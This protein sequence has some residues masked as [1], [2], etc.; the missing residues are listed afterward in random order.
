VG[1]KAPHEM[2]PTTRVARAW[3]TYRALVVPANAIDIQVRECRRAFYA[4]A[5]A[6]LNTF[7]SIEAGPP[8]VDPT[9][10]Q[11]QAGAEFLERVRLELEEFARGVGK[12]GL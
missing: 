2:T 5:Q 7:L 9:E 8:G 3:D 6:I 10:E 12:R 1:D 4:G 11:L